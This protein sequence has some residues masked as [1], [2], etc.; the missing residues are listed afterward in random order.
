MAEQQAIL[1]IGT[2]MN[3]SEGQMYIDVYR[4]PPVYPMSS[5]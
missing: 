5:K 3:V 2:D 1:R 4:Y